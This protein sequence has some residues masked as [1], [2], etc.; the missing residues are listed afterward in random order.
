MGRESWQNHPQGHGEY[1]DVLYRLFDREQYA[2]DFVELGRFRFGSLASYAEIQSESR[3]DAFE[4]EGRVSYRTQTMI[5]AH[6]DT[7]TGRVVRC[8][9]GPG[10]ISMSSSFGNPVFI[11]SFTSRSM[12]SLAALS[13]DFGR[14]AVRCSQPQRLAQQITDH[15]LRAGELDFPIECVRVRYGKGQT[16]DAEPA[17]EDRRVLAYGWKEPHFANECEYRF[18]LMISP[19]SQITSIKGDGYWYVDLGGPAVAAEMFE[20][21]SE[22]SIHD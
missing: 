22:E 4:G 6:I 8:T 17:G 1:P 14:W 9:E 5:S 13:K 21:Q 7:A 3:R 16:F 12:P 20:L 19:A 15:L 2:R 11:M 18:V 10:V